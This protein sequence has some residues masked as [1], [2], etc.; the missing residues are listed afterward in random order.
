MFIAF[1]FVIILAAAINVS[2]ESQAIGQIRKLY[3]DTKS[4][5]AKGELLATQV[6]SIADIKYSDELTEHLDGNG[7]VC[8]F[9]WPERGY[10]QFA[11]IFSALEGVALD[12]EHLFYPDGK[13][14]FCYTKL[15]GVLSTEVF[16]EERFYFDKGI[17]VRY[18]AQRR[19]SVDFALR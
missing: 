5:I 4:M 9:Y 17:L 12:E 7:P 10:L 15:Y 18:P 11:E 6:D 14:A 8:M 13:L 3:Q 1:T 19:S 2:A 16:N